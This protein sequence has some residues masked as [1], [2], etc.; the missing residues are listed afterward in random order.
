MES[1]PTVQNLHCQ[2]YGKFRTE[3]DRQHDYSI[4]FY[5]RARPTAAGLCAFAVL[6]VNP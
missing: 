2:I 4:C 6:D 1:I 3:C 5:R